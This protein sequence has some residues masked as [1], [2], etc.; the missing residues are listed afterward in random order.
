MS[1]EKEIV[2]VTRNLYL[3][4]VWDPFRVALLTV[5]SGSAEDFEVDVLT[6]ADLLSN[7]L[8]N[9][10]VSDPDLKRDLSFEN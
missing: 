6:G 10:R 3:Y 2:V 9:A 1:I 7:H 8:N 5:R 4:Y